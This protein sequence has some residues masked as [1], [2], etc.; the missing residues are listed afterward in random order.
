MNDRTSSSLSTMIAS[1]RYERLVSLIRDLKKRMRADKEALSTF[2]L[3][4]KS[5]LN[6]TDA[7]RLSHELSLQVFRLE[8]RTLVYKSRSQKLLDRAKSLLESRLLTKR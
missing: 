1:L 7:Q 3:G 4:L 8:C 2:T 6:A 5:L